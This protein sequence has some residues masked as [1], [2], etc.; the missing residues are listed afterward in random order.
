MKTALCLVA[1]ILVVVGGLAPYGFGIRIEQIFTVLIQEGARSWNWPMST[2][3]YT[4]GWFCSTA[5]TF[6]AL[7]PG[8]REL[9]RPY[10][11]Q[12]SAALPAG[13]TLV[14]HIQHGPF[15]FAAR[16][17]GVFSLLPVQAIIT[18]ALAPEASG[19]TETSPALPAPQ[20]TTTVLLHGG[21]R[22]RIVVPPFAYSPG[23]PTAARLVWEGLYGEVSVAASGEHLTGALRIPGLTFAGEHGELTLRDV[24]SHTEVST[25]HHQLSRSDTSVRI[26]SLDVTSYSG[27][28][29]PWAVTG[30]ELRTVMTVTD[31]LV[32]AVADVQLGALHV[33]EMPYGPGASHLELRRL[34]LPTL[35]TL[36]REAMGQWQ[37]VQDLTAVWLRLG[38]SGELTRLLAV[39][40]STQPE[41][42]L[43]EMRLHTPAGEIR[44][45]VHMRLDGSR[46]PASGYLPQLL[47]AIDAR[48]EGEAPAAWVQAV[49]AAQ[50]RRTM[51]TRNTV[52]AALPVPLLERLAGT[53]SNRYLRSL[54]EQEYLALDG[55]TYRVKARYRSGQLLVNDKPLH[56]PGLTP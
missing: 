7:P 40:A 30:G 52:A 1:C 25:G 17:D 46:L 19:A 2:S 48:A 29:A 41:M 53:I 49:A 45:S 38:F 23:A 36:L 18:S 31:E 6:V 12:L 43:T 35:F 55:D 21:G 15:P 10:M 33:A 39:F 8:L 44:A 3:H 11:P 20:I 5:A 14:H 27:G 51:R 26:G 50:V 9:L 47:Q 56:L 13:L 34:H 4:R 22:S 32:Q 16:A 54:V 42:A 28:Q 37:E 24:V